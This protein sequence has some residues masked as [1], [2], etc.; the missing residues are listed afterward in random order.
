MR[1]S[2]IS[3]IEITYSYATPA[4]G[5]HQGKPQVPLFQEVPDIE[6]VEIS[7]PAAA[8]DSWCR[9]CA[10]FASFSLS[11]ASARHRRR[12][13]RHFGF[14]NSNPAP[15]ASSPFAILLFRC[16]SNRLM[17][18]WP[19]CLPFQAHQIRWMRAAK[20]AGQPEALLEANCSN[21]KCDERTFAE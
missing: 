19:R 4:F 15:R 18:P 21:R 12:R 1:H 16:H 2:Q 20:I 17:Q 5:L 9:S 8:A 6:F 10:A 11:P 13:C 7:A 14:Q 3:G